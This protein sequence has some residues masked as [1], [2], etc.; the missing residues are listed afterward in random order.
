[1]SAASHVLRRR[2]PAR[3]HARLRRGLRLR[4]PARARRASRAPGALVAV[5]LGAQTVIGVVLELRDDDR[6]RGTRPAAARRPATC[7]PIPADLLG[8]RAPRRASYYLTSFAAALALVCPPTGALKIVR[9]YELT[10]AGRAAAGGRREP[11]RRAG[12]PPAP[13]RPPRRRTPSATGAR[14]GCASPTACTSSASRRRAARCA[15]G[16]E[17]PA[18]LGPRQR[19][20][21]ELVE[22]AGA[23]D[24]RE[25]RAASGLSAA[26]PAPAARAGGAGR[27][28]PAPARTRR[29]ARPAPPRADRRRRRRRRRGAGRPPAGLRHALATSPT[30][31]D[32]QRRALHSI[33]CEAQPGDE[34]LLHGV[35]GS[36]KTEV[37]L[38]AAQATLEA[39]PLGAAPGA[40]DR[41]HRPDRGARARRF[42]GEHGRRA[43]LGPL[44]RR[45]AARLRRRRARRG[46]HRGRAR[47]RRCSRRSSDLGLIVVDEEHDTSYKQESEPAY[48]AR[49]V[50]R[51]RAAA[52]R[53]R[54]RARLGHARAWRASRACPCTPT[55]AR[56]VDGSQPPRLE[57][58][59]MRDHHGV[60]SP[61][62][63]EALDRGRRRRREGHPVPQPPR[64]RLVP[65]LRPLRPHL[66]VSALRRDAD[67]VRQPHACAAAP[68]ATR[69][70]APAACPACGS[71][72]LVRHGL[73]HRAP[74]AR[75]AAAAARAW[76]CCAST[77]TWPAPTRRLRARPGQLRRARPQGPGRHADDRQG[78]SLPGR[79]ARGRGQRR[80][81]AALPGL[82]RRGAHLRPAGA[83][84]RPQRP[85][86][87]GRPR[88]RA[89]ARAR[90]PGPSPWP[91]PGKDERFYAEELERRRELGYPP[92]SACSS[93]SRSRRAREEQVDAAG[94]FTAERLHGRAAAHGEQVL[95]P[96]PLWRE[97]GRH[98]CRVVVKTTRNRENSR[99]A[100]RLAGA[101]TATATPA[102]ACG[103]CR[104][105]S[106]S[107]CEAAA[108]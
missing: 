32:E 56:R 19:A 3:P 99:R 39:R 13:E 54:R 20:A 11:A 101:L 73:R 84:R 5:P 9:Q 4:G 104:T 102:A 41:A 42:A 52:D 96:G 27:G 16:P 58:V 21:L 50:A 90:R 108:A 10:D 34:V 36:G 28:R 59:D 106:R 43:A 91:R 71:S 48:D 1:M 68:A 8:A 31:C 97:R 98:A 47:A 72:D 38:Q 94:R 49:T 22:E 18:R 33:L 23:L 14:A 93:A 78:P 12:R 83:G 63:A 46:A 51:W 86:R 107:G 15:R 17:T 81:H 44:G 69:E 65:R 87:R 74:R 88:H 29:P 95:G 85:R 67:A 7:P 64:L 45:A 100:A 25:L 30:C 82:P 80:P 40:R 77:R 76:S 89:D 79:H 92:A 35:T 57:I 24:E 6:A 105:S 60:F 75:G 61:Q 2:L 37:Y 62:L 103:W 53:R 66:G 70:P 26:G 55:C